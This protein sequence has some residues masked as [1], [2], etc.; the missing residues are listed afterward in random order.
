[1]NHMTSPT[2]LGHSDTHR[3]ERLLEIASAITATRS[4]RLAWP[5]QTDLA[6]ADARR[7]LT[8][9]PGTPRHALSL[10]QQLR[11]HSAIARAGATFI[12]LPVLQDSALPSIN[13]AA[14]AAW[15]AAAADI[16]DGTIDLTDSTPHRLSAYIVASK[17]LLKTAPMLAASYIEAQL[18]SAIGAALDDS[19]VNGDGTDD[20]PVGLLADTGVAEYEMA[21]ASI[22]VADLI[23]MEQAIADAH[24][25][26]GLET[27]AW[28]V[29][30]ATRASLRTLPRMA[31]GTTPAW[32]DDAAAGPLGITGIA[33]PWAPADT[34]ILGRF[35]DLLV[36]QS[37]TVEITPN[38][39]SQDTQ[40]FVRILIQG[41]FDIL[42]LNPAGSFLRAVAAA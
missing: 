31:S 6:V 19:A 27:L 29:D 33:S 2:R 40:G 26:N 35:E 12:T 37:G 32:P 17:Q 39:Y 28:L 20:S 13:R 24:G 30:P 7:D 11:Q 5:D 18:L 14:K 41:W 15:G 21:G 3:R 25:E 23:G 34:A 10:G 1:M 38:P 8:G 36:L 42:A 16:G 9:D 4:A 22:A